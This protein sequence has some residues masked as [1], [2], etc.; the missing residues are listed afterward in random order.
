MY[1]QT[2][3]GLEY[4]AIP[5]LGMRFVHHDIVMLLEGEYK[6]KHIFPIFVYCARR[7]ERL[8]LSTWS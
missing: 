7:R 2:V 6:F 8:L 1:V 4:I 3:L 5:C